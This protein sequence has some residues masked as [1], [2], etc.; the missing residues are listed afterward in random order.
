MKIDLHNKI[1]K[2]ES[3]SPNGEVSEETIFYYEQMEDVISAL[4]GGGA[5]IRGQLIG[6]IVNNEYLDFRY[7]HINIHK[8]IMTGTCKSYLEMTESG[9]IRLN[10][11]WKWTCKD[12]SEGQSSVIE[13]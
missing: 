4:Y 5:I 11:R 10:E 9:K 6:K 3:N 2:T 7:Q 12:R 13:I 8:E 1:F